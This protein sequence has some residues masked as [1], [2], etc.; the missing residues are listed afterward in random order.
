VVVTPDGLRTM[1]QEESTTVHKVLP[2]NK[3]IT[4]KDNYD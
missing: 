3:R 2:I 4:F 1:I